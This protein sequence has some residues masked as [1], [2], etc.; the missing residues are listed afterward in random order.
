MS[1][2]WI[3]KN[4]SYVHNVHHQYLFCSMIVVYLRVFVYDRTIIVFDKFTMVGGKIDCRIRRRVGTW[5]G[6][7]AIFRTSFAARRPC[8]SRR[9]SRDSHSIRFAY[10]SSLRGTWCIAR[11]DHSSLTD[12]PTFN[13]ESFHSYFVGYL[14]ARSFRNVTEMDSK[15]SFMKLEWLERFEDAYFV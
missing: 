9:G 8:T 5:Y 4:L 12:A 6:F 11:A 2:L 15:D 13:F 3:L 10:T 14:R 1:W 7:S